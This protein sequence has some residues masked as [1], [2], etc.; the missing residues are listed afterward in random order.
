MRDAIRSLATELLTIQAT[1]D[2][3]RARA[4]LEKYGISTPEI[5]SVIARLRD[6]P[7]DITPVFPTAGEK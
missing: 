4:P 3:E 1:G 6:I 7:V 5:E 2:Y